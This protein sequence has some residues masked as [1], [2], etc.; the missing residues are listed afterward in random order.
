M[1]SKIILVTFFLLFALLPFA[2]K[3][4]ISILAY[5]TGGQNADSF[6]L[7]KLTHIIFSFGHL[8]GNQLSI[9]DA[10]DSTMIQKLVSYKSRNPNLKVRRSVD[11]WGGVTL[12][13]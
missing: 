7:E 3:K 11:G 6:A 12:G 8:K 13:G 4:D 5:Y 1:A 10:N 2:Q 9:D